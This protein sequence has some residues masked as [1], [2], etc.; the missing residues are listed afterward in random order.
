[1]TKMETYTSP[2]RKSGTPCLEVEA[3]SQTAQE[4]LPAR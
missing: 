3:Y 1:M 4:E 2:A